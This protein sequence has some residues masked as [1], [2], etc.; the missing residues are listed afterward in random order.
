[1]IIC[2]RCGA[3]N[4][5]GA[6]SCA[7]CNTPFAVT[8]VY[9]SNPAYTGAPVPGRGL[10][11]ASMVLG[12]LSLVL[13]CIWFISGPFAVIG[14]ILGVAG[15]GVSKSNG[16][17][18]GT[19]VAGIVCS[20]VTLAILAVFVYLYVEGALDLYEFTRYMDF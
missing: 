19:A 11:I 5:D 16:Y 20:L 7:N 4:Y 9:V 13:F 10:G 15:L 17:G 3:Q 6:Y 18:N 2:P 8:P 12:I 14:L 1:M